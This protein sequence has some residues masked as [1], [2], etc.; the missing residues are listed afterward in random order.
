MRIS[1]G[2]SDGCSSDLIQ[3]GAPKGSSRLLQR[4]GR[5]NHR[6]DEPSEAILIPGNRFEYLEARAALD[7]VEAGERDPDIF[8]PGGLDVLAQHIMAV[9]SA[10]PFQETDLLAEIRSALPYSALDEAIFSEV[11]GFI[12]NGG[13]ALRASDR[14]Q[15]ARAPCTERVCQSV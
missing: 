7:A 11:L 4:I 9:A 15:I 3:M 14:F 10:A 13:Y 6:L 12:Q 5:A 2:S 1:D 8:R